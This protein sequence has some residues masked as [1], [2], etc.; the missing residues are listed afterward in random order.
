MIGQLYPEDG[1]MRRPG[2]SDDVIARPP[3]GTEDGRPNR[4]ESGSGRRT[5]PRR[6][7]EHTVRRHLLDL[8]HT[9]TEV[10]HQSNSYLRAESIDRPEVPLY[11][12]GTLPEPILVLGHHRGVNG[13]GSCKR[14]TKT[15]Q[16]EGVC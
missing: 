10:V 9:V 3:N 14:Q 11:L 7:P 1:D 5:A 15:Y 12:L 2:Q 16:N 6:R 4:E 13:H 8:V